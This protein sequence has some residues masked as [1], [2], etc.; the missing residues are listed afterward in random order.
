M[1]AVVDVSTHEVFGSDIDFRPPRLGTASRRDPGGEHENKDPKPFGPRQKS[2]P[3][4][5]LWRCF[6]TDG[7]GMNLRPSCPHKAG[8]APSLGAEGRHEPLRA[9]AGQPGR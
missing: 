2:S 6:A 5:T 4:L 3:L 8:T 9:F 7:G 1:L